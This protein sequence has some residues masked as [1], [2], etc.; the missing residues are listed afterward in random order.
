MS[1][2][3]RYLLNIYPNL[4]AAALDFGVSKSTIYNYCTKQPE[5]ILV[6]IPRLVA[7]GK[8]NVIGQDEKNSLARAALLSYM[9]NLYSDP[10]E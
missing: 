2:L 5:Q 1:E 6:H 10:K 4:E 9:H 7:E 8:R 3:K